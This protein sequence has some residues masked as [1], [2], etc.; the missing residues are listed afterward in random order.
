[1]FHDEAAG[2]LIAPEAR[3]ERRQVDLVRGFADIAAVHE[4]VQ[5]RQL[6]HH[7]RDHIVQLLAVGYA[8]DQRQVARTHGIPVHALHVAI[9]EV[10]PFQPPRIEK[11]AAEVRARIREERPGGHVDRRLFQRLRIGECSGTRARVD[12]VEVAGLRH[13]ELFAV[14]RDFE[15]LDVAR[16]GL[17][18]IALVGDLQALQR[19]LAGRFVGAVEPAEALVGDLQIVIVARR[20]RHLSEDATADR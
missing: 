1:M 16:D 8:I 2:L 18:F 19:Q 13:Q 5:C 12:D 3:A 9:V 14:E 4:D 7:L 17:R 6:A 10:I 11:D 20:R 15:I